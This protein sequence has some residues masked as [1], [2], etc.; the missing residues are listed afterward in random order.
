MATTST[1]AGGQPADQPRGERAEP[2]EGDGGQGGDQAGHGA[3]EA[4]PDADLVEQGAEAGDRGPQVERDQQ[5]PDQHQRRRRSPGRRRRRGRGRVRAGGDGGRGG[6]DGG[7]AVR[8]WRGHD[9]EP[10]IMG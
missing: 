3:G 7:A 10:T 1:R 9:L 5:H 2:G 6:L 4:Q 8:R